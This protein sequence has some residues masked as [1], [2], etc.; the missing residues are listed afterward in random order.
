MAKKPN[1]YW[2]EGTIR[3]EA[4]KHPTRSAFD[5]AYPGAVGTARARYPGLLDELYPRLI[6]KYL[7]LEDSIRLAKQYQT[8]GEFQAGSSAAYNRC[9]RAGIIHA[10]GFPTGLRGYSRFKWSED[11]VRTEATKY[12][13]KQEFERLARGAAARARKLGI[14]DDLGLLEY[15]PSDNDAIYIWREV[16]AFFNGNPV[17][18]I[19]VT[20]VRLGTA[21]IE[22]VA[23]ESGFEYDLI[24]CE[25][26]QGRADELEKKLL[27][28]GESPGYTGFNGATEFRALSDS[29]L[30]AAVSMI[31][32]SL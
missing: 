29:A 25:S 21:R 17:Y 23:H 16:G 18:K 27:I 30:Y 2:N 12:E 3:A 5:A 1:G 13:T 8:I 4:A 24:C 6:S 14:I 28:L 11:K 26:V 22:S 7:T 31:C 9:R 32:A 15:P 10:L 20:S 19:G